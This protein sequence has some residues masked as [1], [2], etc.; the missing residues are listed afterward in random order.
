M[1]I[2]CIKVTDFGL[3]SLALRILMHVSIGNCP[4]LGSSP[5]LGS[6]PDL[7]R[8]L[9]NLSGLP[10]LPYAWW[11]ILQN[12]LVRFFSGNVIYDS[13]ML[14]G[15][16]KEPI[17]PPCIPRHPPWGKPMACTLS[18]SSHT[19]IILLELDPECSDHRSQDCYQPLHLHIYTSGLTINCTKKLK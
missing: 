15:R 7:T 9:H 18:L 11:V 3:H 2:K 16:R 19:L 10:T 12:L 1:K 5:R 17:P 13:T 8:G 14:Q 6:S 4:S